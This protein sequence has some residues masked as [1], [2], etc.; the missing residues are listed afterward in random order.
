MKK[1]L[2]CKNIHIQSFQ[3][4]YNSGINVAYTDEL[5]RRKV[6]IEFGGVS[7]CDD[8]YIYD[9]VTVSA[10][11]VEGENI[12]TY[13]LFVSGE[14]LGPLPIFRIIADAVDYIEQCDQIN[15]LEELKSIATSYDYIDEHFENREYYNNELFKHAQTRQLI[16]EGRVNVN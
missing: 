11:Y 16:K 15:L 4:L 7:I 13:I 9:E 12:H 3:D 2:L 6:L 10:S 14:T 5:L 1:L 8:P